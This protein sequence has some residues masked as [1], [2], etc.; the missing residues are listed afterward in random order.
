MLQRRIVTH[1][2][3]HAEHT[4]LQRRRTTGDKGCRGLC[5]K[6]VSL[7]HHQPHVRTFQ[8]RLIIRPL[9]RGCPRQ[10]YVILAG[11]ITRGLNHRRQVVLNFLLTRT[12]E[13]GYNISLS[14]LLSPLSSKISPL[15]SKKLPHLLCRRVADIMDGEMVFLFKEV[16]LERQDGEEF[17]DIALDVLDAVL[18]PRPYLR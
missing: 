1:H 3:R 6:R 2:L 18:L 15:S 14:S 11:Q 13:Q 16:H 9:Y 4:G 8:K 17:V 5:Q 7:V 12:G 10:Y